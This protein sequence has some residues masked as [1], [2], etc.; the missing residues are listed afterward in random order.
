MS[1]KPLETRGRALDDAFYPE[2]AEALRAQLRERERAAV[3]A[4]REASDVADEA[5]LE[6][7]AGL[8]IRPETLAA[9]TMIPI[10]E[11]A[12]ADGT[13]DERER[14]AI[15]SGA[16]STGIE[17]GTPSHGLLGIWTEDRPAPAL[18]EAWIS[19]MQALLAELG[20][21]QRER[22]REKLI[23]R[24]RAVAEAAGGTL[25]LGAI[26]R[27]EGAVLEALERTL[28]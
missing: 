15:L 19:F 1:E 7:L 12:W 28:S 26:S 24:A 11:V 14:E 27:E 22:L 21:K 3:D 4:L 2:R 23:A 6:T 20:P 13:M 16:E 9:L 17:R 8:G 18:R 25:G 10:V 5:T